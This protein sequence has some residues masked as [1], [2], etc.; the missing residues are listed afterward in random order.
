MEC[1]RSK[2]FDRDS[3]AVGKTSIIVSSPGASA[4]NSDREANELRLRMEGVVRADGLRSLKS[5]AAAG[6]LRS[7][8]GL[9]GG[10]PATCWA[11]DTGGVRPLSSSCTTGMVADPAVVPLIWNSFLSL[12]LSSAKTFMAVRIDDRFSSCFARSG[13]AR[14][15]TS[16]NC[17]KCSKS[18]KDELLKRLGAMPVDMPGTGATPTGSSPREKDSRRPSIRSELRNEYPSPPPL[19]KSSKVISETIDGHEERLINRDLRC[20]TSI[21]FGGPEGC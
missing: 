17:C 1:C 8:G 13:H 11:P 7:L 15:K 21:D 20:V 6:S 14:G 18:S 9:S 3:S 12:K 10:G 19:L 5:G 16:S 2:Y 4:S